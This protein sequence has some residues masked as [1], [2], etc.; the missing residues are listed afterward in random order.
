VVVVVVPLDLPDDFRVVVVVLVV[1]VGAIVGGGGVCNAA[2]GG[3]FVGFSNE[4]P[5][6]STNI[7]WAAG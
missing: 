7:C 3:G 2:L 1:V 5:N 4:L 6:R